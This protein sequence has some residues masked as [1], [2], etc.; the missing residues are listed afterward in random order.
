M[1]KMILS[2]RLGSDATVRFFNERALI[3]FAV[4][5]NDFVLGN[6][7]VKYEKTQWVSC[8]L[9]RSREQIN[10]AK[11]LRKGATVCVV[12]NPSFKA[13]E[14]SVDGK[15]FVDLEVKELDVV[16]YAKDY[17]EG[18]NGGSHPQNGHST[19]SPAL[20]EPKYDK[21]VSVSEDSHSRSASY[22]PTPQ[23]AIHASVAVK[24]MPG[25]NPSKPFPTSPAA[26]GQLPPDMDE[27]DEALPF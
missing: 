27:D 14:N 8:S 21:S 7:G 1:M 4:A 24:N 5:H 26:S 9:W 10:I 25:M 11:V 3:S 2:G 12:G 19:A 6:D 16:Q 13:A 20:G 15:V 17:P 23:S 18:E 22:R